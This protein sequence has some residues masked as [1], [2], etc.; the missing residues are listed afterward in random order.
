LGAVVAGAA[1][2][3]PFLVTLSAHPILMFGGSSILLA[4]AAWFVFFRPMQCPADPSLARKCQLARDWNQRIWW[5]SVVLWSLGF[6]ARF[7]LPVFKQLLA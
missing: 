5:L 3:F 2:R 6:S 7:V 1:F 4:V